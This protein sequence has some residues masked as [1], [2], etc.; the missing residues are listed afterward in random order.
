MQ[1]RGDIAAEVLTQ[2]SLRNARTTSQWRSEGKEGKRG[3][4]EQPPGVELMLQSTAKEEEEG[5]GGRPSGGGRAIVMASQW[6]PKV[7]WLAPGSYLG[8][9]VV[10]R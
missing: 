7:L 10:I 5:G 3:R 9:D 8:D 2:V 1:S 4:G 6:G